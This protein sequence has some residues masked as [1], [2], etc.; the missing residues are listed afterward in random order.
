M[1]FA[2]PLALVP[3]RCDP[4]L[5]NFV[6]HG[7]AN[8]SGRRQSVF[9]DAGFWEVSY[10]L[11]LNT[12][13]RVRAWRGTLARLRQGEEVDMPVWDKAAP[14]GA[15]SKDEDGDVTMASAADA[16]AVQIVLRLAG[17][18]IDGGTYFSIGPRFH[19]VSEVVSNGPTSVF[20]IPT[21]DNVF[22]DDMIPWTDAD[23]GM[24]DVTVKIMPPLRFAVASGA[25][26][27]LSNCVMRGELADPNDGETQTD[28]GLYGSVS[29]TIREA[30]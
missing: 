25:G 24:R 8:S 6:K 26:V 18:E 27:R 1:A 4:N 14:R 21:N 16:R 15:V 23:P 13:E 9:S 20:D 10:E 2:W 5:R 28:L 11:P 3:R 17:A 29:F 12:P 22:W 7:A 30:I 19:M